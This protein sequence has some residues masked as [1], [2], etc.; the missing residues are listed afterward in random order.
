M[1]EAL[2]NSKQVTAS[3]V[4]LHDTANLNVAAV[5]DLFARSLEGHSLQENRS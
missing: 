4:T 5:T 2:S 1:T 3:D